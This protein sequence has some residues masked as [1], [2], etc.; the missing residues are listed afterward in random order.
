MKQSTVADAAGS[1][2]TSNFNKPSTSTFDAQPPS[3]FGSRQSAFGQ[4]AFGQTAFGTTPSAF[5]QPASTSTMTGAFGQPVQPPSSAFGTSAFGQTSQPQSNLIKPASGA[6]SNFA[7]GPSAFG[8]ATGSGSTGGGFAAF[9]KQPTPFGLAA[10]APQPTGGSAFGQPAFGAPSAFAAPLQAQ[11]QQQPPQAQ[12]AFGTF[13]QPTA[14]PFAPTQSAFAAPSM[15]SQ[16]FGNTAITAFET[17]Q[18]PQQTTAFSAFRPLSTT[19]SPFAAQPQSSGFSASA[20]AAPSSVFGA[21]LH[22]PATTGQG[23]A[24]GTPDFMRVIELGMQ[25]LS[26]PARNTALYKAGSSPYDGL[27]GPDY[28]QSVPKEAVEAFKSK[29]FELGKVPECLPP[30]EMR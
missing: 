6:F 28:A 21:P 14:S 11:Q 4:P 10:S 29:T 7:T 19:A 30:L 5:G 3:A 8:G 17:V 1:T 26:G 23:S 24:T 12:S 15:Q 27:L 16:P 18:P 2:N 13:G 25:Q 20:S 22:P 9:A